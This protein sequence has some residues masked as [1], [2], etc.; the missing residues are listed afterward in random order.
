MG[1]SAARL[2]HPVKIMEK[3]FLDR[4]HVGFIPF[5]LRLFRHT[6]VGRNRYTYQDSQKDHGDHQLHQGETIPIC[7]FLN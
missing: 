4:L 2:V 5:S 3:C 6:I 7:P 1:G